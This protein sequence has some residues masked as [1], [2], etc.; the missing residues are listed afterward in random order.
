[1]TTKNSNNQHLH[2][3]RKQQAKD[4][5]N[6]SGNTIN[7]YS[8]FIVATSNTDVA[9]ILKAVS[10]GQTIGA[11]D[12]DPEDMPPPA[13]RTYTL[14]P[15]N[16]LPDD[17]PEEDHSTLSPLDRR[18]LRAIN[19]L[20]KEKVLHYGYDYAWIM[21]TMNDLD[22]MP[23]H[24]SVQGFLDYLTFLGLKNLPTEGTLSRY[25]RY[26]TGPLTQWTFG[27]QRGK[28]ATEAVRRNNVARRFIS[29]FRKS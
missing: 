24:N 19:V 22:D 4:I 16:P 23:H 21:R 25:L 1:M 15:Q 2:A 11:D 8:T 18:V 10:R 17:D 28:G 3:V 12:E 6:Q 20:K 14:I 9:E 7:N 26:T 27:D 29:A 5:Y 13:P